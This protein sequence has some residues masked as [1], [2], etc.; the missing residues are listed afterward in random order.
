MCIICTAAKKRHIKR[1]EVLES[2]RINSSG[3]FMAALRPDGTRDTIRTLDSNEAIRFFDEKVKDEDAFVMHARIPSR[4]LK[5]L[6]NVHGWEADNILFMHNMTLSDLDSMM[7]KVKWEGT[8]SEFF[9]KKIFLPYYR[10]LGEEAYKNGKFHEDLDNLIDHFCGY[11]N[12][13]CFIM[14]DNRVIRYGTWVSEYDRKENGEVAFY[15]SNSGYKVTSVTTWKGG[16]AAGAAGFRGGAYGGY[17][18]TYG[19]YDGYDGEL[20]GAGYAGYYNSQGWRKQAG[21]KKSRKSK[22]DGKMQK[23]ADFDG[24]MLLK[25]AGAKGVCQLALAHMVIENAITGRYI[26]SETEAEKEVEKIIRGILPK[27]FDE[28][29]T[30]GLCEAFEELAKSKDEG[31]DEKAVTKYVERFASNVSVLYEYTMCHE[32]APRAVVPTEWAVNL[33]IKE[34]C[35]RVNSLARLLNLKMDFK[36]TEPDKVSKCFVLSGDEDEMIEIMVED[37]VGFDTLSPDDSADAL[38]MLLCYI[39]DSVGEYYS[40]AAAKNTGD[41]EGADADADANAD[42][43]ED[44]GAETI[45]DADAASALDNVAT[46]DDIDPLETDDDGMVIIDDDATTVDVQDGKDNNKDGGGKEAV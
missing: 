4:G 27:C 37:L 38:Q 35:K 3:F 11:S 26:Y 2:M 8:D 15:A 33:G 1:E 24:K 32:Q 17:G 45:G 25:L 6:A 14:P 16:G 28:V 20:Y 9:F 19:G 7:K 29:A 22:Q 46:C 21:S 40:Y 10:G 5:S 12:K 30:A 44:T 39:N 18:G 36:T 42:G 43:A 13:F 23:F 34:T 31:F 41:D